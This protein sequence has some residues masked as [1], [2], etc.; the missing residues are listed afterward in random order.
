MYQ[1]FPDVKLLL[2]TRKVLSCLEFMQRVLTPLLWL[3]ILIFLNPQRPLYEQV[4]VAVTIAQFSPALL[5]HL[6]NDNDS[7]YFC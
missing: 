6:Y 7:G 5:V 4:I 3:Y 1:K 2:L